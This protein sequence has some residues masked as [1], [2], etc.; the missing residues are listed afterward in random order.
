MKAYKF[1][2]RLTQAVE[3]KIEATLALC[4]ELYNAGLAERRGAYE[5]AG[6]SIRYPEQ[7]NQLP[8]IKQLREEF[9]GVHSQVLQQTLKRLQLAFDNFFRR[10]KAG[11]PAGYPRF[12]SRRRYDSFTYPQS[13]WRLENRKL[14]LSKIGSCRVHLSRPIEGQIKT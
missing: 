14:Y 11:P 3:R 9:S 2:L 7:A 8:Q 6:K 10:R 13:G 5:I 12:R 4:C 1:K